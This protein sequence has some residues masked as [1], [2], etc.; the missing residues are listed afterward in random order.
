[1][2]HFSFS[3]DSRAKQIKIRQYLVLKH[4]MKPWNY[5]YLSYLSDPTA[6]KLYVWQARDLQYDSGESIEQYQVSDLGLKKR[7]FNRLKQYNLLHWIYKY[8]QRT[9]TTELPTSANIPMAAWGS[10]FVRWSLYSNAAVQLAPITNSTV[11]EIWNRNLCC[12]QVRTMTSNFSV[13]R[14]TTQIMEFNS[15]NLPA[16]PRTLRSR[17][18]CSLEITTIATADW[19]PMALIWPHSI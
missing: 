9:V 19:P 2:N 6:S 14:S 7:L 11:K 3:Y 12:G 1:M 17:H 15:G 8:E 13:G 18:T 5:Y 16:L 4:S 10:V